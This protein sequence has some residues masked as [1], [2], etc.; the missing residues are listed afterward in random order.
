MLLTNLLPSHISFELALTQGGE[1][2]SCMN[3]KTSILLSIR[4]DKKPLGTQRKT[5]LLYRSPVGY[6]TILL[7]G[8]S[9]ADA[10]STRHNRG[11]CSCCRA[12]G[13][14]GQHRIC[15]SAGLQSPT[16]VILADGK[17]ST[18]LRDPS[19]QTHALS[20]PPAPLLPFPG[21]VLARMAKVVAAWRGHQGDTVDGKNSETFPGVV[22]F[23]TC[24]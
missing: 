13:R 14:G 24:S 19:H 7:H 21:D 16:A 18:L 5:T 20:T 11:P 2:C 12:V 3:N 1:R 10:G 9:L 17:T 6:S 22:V 23:L 15:P 4:R 8:A